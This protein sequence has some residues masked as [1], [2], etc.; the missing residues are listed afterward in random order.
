MSWLTNFP[1]WHWRNEPLS[2][3][4][5]TLCAFLPNFVLGAS[6]ART[7]GSEARLWLIV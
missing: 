5:V 2:V 3:T 4:S 7:G 6:Y 1:V